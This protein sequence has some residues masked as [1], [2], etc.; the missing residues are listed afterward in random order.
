MKPVLA[1]AACAL[2]LSVPSLG[3]ASTLY[4]SLPDN[5]LSAP[6][7]TTYSGS[8]EFQLANDSIVN[9]ATV[10]IW[11]DP[12]QAPTTL[13]WAIQSSA[14]SGVLFSG[15]AATLT[16]DGPYVVRNGLY[17]LYY[18]TF[19]IPDAA[20]TAG[21]YWLHLSN[22]VGGPGG[23][24]WGLNSYSGPDVQFQGQSSVGIG[25][26]AFSIDNVVSSAP[27]P[28]TWLLFVPALAGFAAVIRRRA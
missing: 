25:K 16:D 19:T 26:Y 21:D 28:A 7:I 14:G 6:D 18:A 9:S 17:S 20:L 4:S 12:N 27:E 13:D 8:G 1:L 22:C 3:S 15:T 2:A 23:C 10:A 5:D 11:V 24:G